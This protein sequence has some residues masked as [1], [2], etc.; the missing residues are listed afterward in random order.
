MQ[1]KR[2]ILK[3]SRV[4][5]LRQKRRAKIRRRFFVILF[6]VAAFVAGLSYLS[7]IEPTRIEQVVI[8]GNDTIDTDAILKSV[9]DKIIGNYVYLFSKQ[10]GL[11]YPQE[12]IREHVLETFKRLSDVALDLSDL[13]TLHV[14]VT[15]RDARYLWC[16]HDFNE[17]AGET[18]RA[19]CYYID[20]NGYIFS[21]APYFSGD[22]FFK[23]YGT[24]LF[25]DSLAPV[26]QQFL[27]PDDFQK[28]LDFRDS[29]IALGLQTYGLVLSPDGEYSLYI[30]PLSAERPIHTKIEFNK[31][32]DLTNIT[33]NLRAALL[34]EPFATDFKKKFDSLLYIDLRFTNKV[35]YKFAQ[36]GGVPMISTPDASSAATATPQ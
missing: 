23:F 16:G 10:N 11:I 6:S 1:N 7:K 19:D 29:I 3:P 25:N 5:E 33:E 2:E 4:L 13:H 21:E 24:G 14:Y 34:T 12:A 17:A 9:Q 18:S 20:A 31:K 27:S 15:E 36:A 35:Y 28:L 30:A 8:S 22:V 26:G 32:N